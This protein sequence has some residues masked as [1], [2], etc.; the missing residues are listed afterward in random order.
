MF[1]PYSQLSV[2][3]SNYW[4]LILCITYSYVTGVGP[5]IYW[6]LLPFIYSY[7]TGLE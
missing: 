3:P 2:K 5:S 4:L 1:S 6:L 7:V